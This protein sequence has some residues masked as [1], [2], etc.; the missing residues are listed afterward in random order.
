MYFTQKIYSNNKPLILTNNSK[1]YRSEHPI[2]EGYMQFTGAFTRNYRLAISHLEK[3]TSLGAII[4]DVS[5][6]SLQK[7]LYDIYKPVD[8]G[9]GV[10][11]N[12]NDS[13]LM[14]F[15]RGKWD[16]PKG[17]RDD[18]EDIGQCAVREVSEETGLQQIKLGKKIGDTYHIYSQN[19]ENLLKCTAWYRMKA[20]ALETL[21]PQKE[22]NIIEAR[23]VTEG[24]LSSIAY[25]SYEAIREVLHLAGFK[26]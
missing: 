6:E 23:W 24:E 5:P 13:V 18:G 19:N 17:K 22:E 12:E 16:L 14:I 7:E 10:V 26:W 3:I 11:L 21:T 4:E 9:G 1:Q 25:K 20:S 15:R 2:A 8:A